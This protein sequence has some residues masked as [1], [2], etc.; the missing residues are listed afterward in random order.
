V[1][2]TYTIA[3]VGDKREWSND[4]GAFWAYPLTVE[5][6]SG[7]K[8]LGVEWSR[9]QTSRAPEVGER[10]VAEIQGGP[11]GEKLKVDLNATKELS[12]GS[13]SS[14]GSKSYEAKSWQPE[15][16]RD[17]ERAARILRQHSQEMALRLSTHNARGEAI[18]AEEVFELADLFDADV[19]K[20]AQGVGVLSRPTG[21]GAPPTPAQ[22]TQSNAEYLSK[23]LEEAGFDLAQVT[24]V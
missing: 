20:A 23:L 12:G 13:T 4:H 21:N 16:Q 8:H 1:S 22:E 3:E 10:V 11:H 9:K 5:D 19:I 14:S 7:Q 24:V 15:A 6:S 2:D 18:P 17:P